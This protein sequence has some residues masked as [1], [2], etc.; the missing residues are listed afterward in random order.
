MPLA[1]RGNDKIF[2]GRERRNPPAKGGQASI[3]L[4][5]RGRE[6]EKGRD[7]GRGG[8]PYGKKKKAGI[9]PGSGFPPA[10]E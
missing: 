4:Y 10:R 5:Q 9:N 2:R 3:P 7:G 6:D 1:V 8:P